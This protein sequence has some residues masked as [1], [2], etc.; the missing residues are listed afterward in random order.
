MRAGTS[1]QIATVFYKLKSLHGFEPEGKIVTVAGAGGAGSAVFTQLALDGVVAINIF[2]RHDDFWDVTKEKVTELASKTGVPMVLG[3]LDD[4]KL[5]A[6]A[7]KNSDL[8][9]NA[10]RVGMAPF[11]D[12][13]VEQ[14]RHEEKRQKHCRLPD[15]SGSV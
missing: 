1:S 5:L 12:E 11:D 14:L 9:V 8:F 3:D 6:R 4:K 13:C 10:T 7:V 2:N 15:G